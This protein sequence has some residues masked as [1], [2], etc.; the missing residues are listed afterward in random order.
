MHIG[1]VISTGIIGLFFTLFVA[2]DLVLFGVIAS[3]S[4]VVTVLLA[5][6]LVGGGTLGFL[7]GKRHPAN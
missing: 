5:V 1:R 4:A 6:G 2:L 7:A 3:N